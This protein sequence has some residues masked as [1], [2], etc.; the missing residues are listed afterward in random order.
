MSKQAPETDVLQVII[1]TVKDWLR[2][3]LPEEW[4][5]AWLPVAE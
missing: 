3:N 5:Y 2:V 1:D 4:A